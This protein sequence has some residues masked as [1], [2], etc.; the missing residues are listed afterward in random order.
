MTYSIEYKK[1]AKKFLDEHPKE[2]IHFN[3]AFTDIANEDY[4]SYDIKKMVA[5]SEIYRLR[6]GKY[7]A[8][9]TVINDKLVILVLDIDSRGQ[10]YK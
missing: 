3:K 4:K 7:R 1:K 6:L 2:K 8:L 5:T 9:F 10:I